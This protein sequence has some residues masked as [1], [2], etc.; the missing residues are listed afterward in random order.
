M[1]SLLGDARFALRSFT[2]DPVLYAT[3]ALTLALGIGAN[4]AIFSVVDT[5]LLRPLPYEDPEQIMEV[6]TVFEGFDLPHFW[7][8]EKE[9]L[10]FREQVD[11]FSELAAY[12]TDRAVLTGRGEPR[13]LQVERVSSDFFETLGQSTWRGRAFLPDEELPGQT[14]VAV[15]SHALW[16]EVFAADPGV[17]GENVL[18]DD[19]PYVLVGVLPQGFRSP[20]RLEEGNETDLWIPLELDPAD[21]DLGNHYLK[22]I[23]LLGDG[24]SSDQA[25]N[26]LA[27]AVGS[28][29]ESFPDVYLDRYGFDAGVGSLSD[30]LVG[31]IRPVLL[32]LLAA[33]ALVLLIACANIAN[34]LLARAEKRRNEM[35]IRSALGAG[36]WHIFRHLL[37]EN[38]LLALIGGGLGLGLA[39]LGLDFLRNAAEEL[40]PAAGAVRLDPPVILFTAGISIL[41]GLLF[42]VAPAIHALASNLQ[43]F[44]KGEQRS[45]TDPG[46]RWARG[47]L[48]VAE[49]ALAV[50][51]TVAAGL[52]LHS[53]RQLVAT[54]PGFDP[55]GVLA[56]EFW[57]PEGRY[58]EEHQ[59]TGFFRQT[60]DRLE[61]MPSVTTAGVIATL[62]LTEPP[63][64]LNFEIPG[65]SVNSGDEPPPLA[66]FQLVRSG[67]FAALDI[68]LL[69]GRT[70]RDSD[71][72]AAPAVAVV[73]QAF[74]DRHLDGHDPLGRGILLG[75]Q[76]EGDAVYSIVGV[77][78]NVRQESLTS[79]YRGTMFIP[80][81]QISRTS[82]LLPRR[83]MTVVLRTEGAMEAVVPAVK[84]AVWSVDD[85]MPAEPEPLEDVVGQ[86][87]ARNRFTAFLMA[88]FAG[89]G[90]LLA[91]VGIYGVMSY[92]ATRRSHEV[93]IRMALGAGRSQILGLMASQGMVVTVLGLGIGT[94]AALG[95]TRVLSGLLYGVSAQD[96]AV[97]LLVVL[98]LGCVALGATLI[99]A[100]RMTRVNPSTTL[101]AE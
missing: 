101:K 15:V 27:S 77:V 70:F 41:S 53:L 61:S 29:K 51:L 19:E 16:R 6:W 91:A 57:V 74:V 88:L 47:V 1:N 98:V 24:R 95:L 97:Y 39:F 71:D 83:L 5:V 26:Q 11:A 76:E 81:E 42:G 25:S 9:F 28:L 100:M 90:L 54:D 20:A 30:Q 67:Y 46:R 8:S 32:I 23:G 82:G 14:R 94:L 37:T 35:A 69:A 17:L 44:L 85:L 52:L 21:P 13:Q 87:A 31:D 63:N 22:A 7:L 45:S 10:E 4:T 48:V 92:S 18:L 56:M 49:L 84:Q 2:R 73:D 3:A 99:P 58:P 89:V 96:P 12:R 38:M 59:L 40:L 75:N 64:K 86:A 34:L 55:E 80:H 93:G 65:V 79:E 60:V 50:V 66:D 33:V 62:P 36:R 68:P 78:G 43:E 72:A